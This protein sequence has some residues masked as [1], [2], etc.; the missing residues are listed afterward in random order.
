MP[1]TQRQLAEKINLSQMTVCRALRGDKYVKPDVRRRVLAAARSHGYPLAGRFRRNGAALKHVICSIVNAHPERDSFHVRILAGIRRG[2]EEAG[3]QLINV[4][5][6]PSQWQHAPDRTSEWPLVI[7][8]CLVDGVLQLFG[9]FEADRP[10][11]ACPVPHVS[12]FCAMDD[13]SDT[14]TVDNLGGARALGDYLGG[15]G[16]RRV[17]FIGPVT[18]VADD[19]L[20]GLRAGLKAHGGA[21]PDDLAIQKRAIGGDEHEIRSI[22]DAL[23]PAGACDPVAVRARLTAIAAYNDLMAA[24]AIDELARRGLRV[25]EDV[26]VTGF[27]DVRP[28]FYQGPALTTAALPLEDLGLEAARLLYWR[29]D[30][31]AAIPRT[32]VLGT[33]FVKG[34]TAGKA[35]G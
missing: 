31:P 19:R 6:A 28:P 27:D 18:P 3:A 15:L 4:D 23:L 2:I 1:I 29:M 21:I 9:G 30:F 13:T 11:Y 33:K 17:A 35:E 22:L 8:R 10:R 14:A 25:P 5:D 16:H 7:S 26:S 12:I 34:E 20:L 32:L 24:H